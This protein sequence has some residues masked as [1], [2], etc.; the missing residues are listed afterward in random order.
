VFSAAEAMTNCVAIV[1]LRN[2][3][4]GALERQDGVG[5][6]ECGEVSIE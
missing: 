2:N 5:R 3:V 1:H 6:L 4:G